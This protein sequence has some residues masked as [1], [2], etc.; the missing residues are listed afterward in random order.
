MSIFLRWWVRSAEAFSKMWVLLLRKRYHHKFSSSQTLFQGKISNY[1]E[2]WD[3]GFPW[4]HPSSLLTKEYGCAIFPFNYYS[5]SKQLIL[6]SDSNENWKV[7]INFDF[8]QRKIGPM[9]FNKRK[10]INIFLH[11]VKLIKSKHLL[12]LMK[13]KNYYFLYLTINWNL[14]RENIFD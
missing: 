10:G 14:K 3:A 4:F 2:S 12:L 8:L 9:F 13:I 5:S 1:F 7:E 6:S 11:K